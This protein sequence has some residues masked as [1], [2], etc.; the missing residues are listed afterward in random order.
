MALGQGT[1]IKQIQSTV[2]QF[3]KGFGFGLLPKDLLPGIIIP[4]KT[5][6]MRAQGIAAGGGISRGIK[7]FGMPSTRTQPTPPGRPAPTPVRTYTAK[8]KTY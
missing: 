2:Q 5:A 1:I 8:I 7:V 4:K 6:G 3:T